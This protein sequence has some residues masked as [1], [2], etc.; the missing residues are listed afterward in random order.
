MGQYNMLTTKEFRSVKVKIY[1][2]LVCVRSTY[3]YAL[4]RSQVA[5]TEWWAEK[6]RDKGVG[7]Y[8]M[9]PGWA[10]TPG[11]AKSLPG[12]SEK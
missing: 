10:D 11:V 2:L 9:H 6:Y 1:F 4:G 3:E 7:F 8:S 12:F 5:V